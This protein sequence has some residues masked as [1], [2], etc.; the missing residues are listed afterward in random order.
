MI[1]IELKTPRAPFTEHSLCAIFQVM[2]Q[3]DW[4]QHTLDLTSFDIVLF[5]ERVRAPTGWTGMPERLE[6]VNASVR[7]TYNRLENAIRA[8]HSSTDWYR[9]EHLRIVLHTVWGTNQWLSELIA[10]IPTDPFEMILRDYHDEGESVDEVVLSGG[11]LLGQ[12]CLDVRGHLA[13][14]RSLTMQFDVPG[15]EH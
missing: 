8:N 3:G 14:T 13:R 11:R 5:G 15:W 4:H 10:R 12:P 6:F 1:N 2:A 9:W 7:E